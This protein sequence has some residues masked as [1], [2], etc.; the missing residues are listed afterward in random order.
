MFASVVKSCE[1]FDKIL[2]EKAKF[3]CGEQRRASN[4][5][6]FASFHVISK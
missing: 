2:Y 4:G 5:F 6:N 3:T 1:E